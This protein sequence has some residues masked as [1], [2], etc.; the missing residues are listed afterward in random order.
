MTIGNALARLPRYLWAAPCSAAGLVVALC[1][2]LLG[3]EGRIRDGTI[4]V[5]GGRLATTISRL[6]TRLSIL[7]FTNGHVIF[8]VSQGAMDAYREHE[9][10]HVRQYERWG[11][12]FPFLY[13][14][15]SLLQKVRGR[16]PYFANH[17]EQEARKADRSMHDKGE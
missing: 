2:V 6:P 11:P 15:S 1:A 3:A 14:G 8:A 12:L 17:F 13:L 10:V 4:Q 16:D 5:V 7:A 9:L